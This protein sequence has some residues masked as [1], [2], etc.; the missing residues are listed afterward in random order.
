MR[1]TICNTILFGTYLVD[2]WKQPICA[3]HKVEYCASC[4]RFVK[5]T[6][7][8]LADGRCVCSYCQPGI[9]HTPQ[10][11]QWVEQQVRT[12]L[13]KHGF[14]GLPTN[15]PI[16][17]VT[18][19]E[20]AKENR[21]GIINLNQAGLTRYSGVSGVS[22]IRKE[23]KIFV[24]NYLQKIKF[25]A[26]LAHE[27]LHAW[28][29]EKGISLSAPMTEGLCNLGAYLV[30]EEINQEMSRVLIKSLEDDHD[31]IYGDGFRKV[32][33]LYKQLGSVNK[34]VECLVRNE[35]QQ[36]THMIENNEYPQ[37]WTIYRPGLL[38]FLV[39]QNID[40]QQQT[41]RVA[42]IINNVIDS[43]IQRNFNGDVAINRC[44]IS[45]IGYNRNVKELCSGWLK[46]LDE[47]PT[48]RVRKSKRLP[49]GAG[50]SCE[51]DIIQPVWVEPTTHDG[52][53]DLQGAL[54]NAK[55]LVESWV[56]KNPDGY[57]PIIFNISSG[58]P[59]Y[60]GKNPQECMNAC[61]N[62]AKSLMNVSHNNYSTLLLNLVLKSNDPTRKIRERYLKVE[63]FI[64]NISS[65]LPFVVDDTVNRAV[66]VVEL[67]WATSMSNGYVFCEKKSE[68]SAYLYAFLEVLMHTGS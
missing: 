32:L 1:C 64:K 20:M 56:A 60:A 49:D 33:A 68:L 62:V 63:D 42:D 26:V 41:I 5:P 47:N 22:S 43:I 2:G 27:L 57:A 15:I 24:L 35:K 58:V 61:V 59:Y 11:I 9:V 44:F 66:R 19:Q 21:T 30:L 39:D 36:N 6:D 23:Y 46:D 12:M 67:P 38:V 4:G 65:E 16:Q 7:I 14:V 3:T 48:R 31:L 50:G 10:H 40:D 18:P 25:A 37:S 13:A 55:E 54:Q 17:I 8:H 52:S 53:S 45:V 28:Q 34:V 29:Y 51:V